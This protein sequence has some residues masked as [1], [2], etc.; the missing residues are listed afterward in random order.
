[1]LPLGSSFEGPDRTGIGRM[2]VVVNVSIFILQST[3]GSFGLKKG[4]NSLNEDFLKNQDVFSFFPTGILY[5]F[6]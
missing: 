1:M 2:A 3:A 6:L 4:E 5:F